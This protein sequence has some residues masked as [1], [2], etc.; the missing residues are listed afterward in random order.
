ML[1]AAKSP[2]VHA[3]H[4]ENRGDIV[5]IKG[6]TKKRLHSAPVMLNSGVG[7][8]ERTRK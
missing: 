6:S 5:W 8:R 4:E 7:L 3:G 1:T 2:T